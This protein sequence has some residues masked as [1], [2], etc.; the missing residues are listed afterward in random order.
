[1]LSMASK[2]RLERMLCRL[3]TLQTADV[4]IAGDFCSGE[5]LHS[6]PLHDLFC[7]L[8]KSRSGITSRWVFSADPVLMFFIFSGQYYHEFKETTEKQP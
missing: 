6:S 8:V 4:E 1:M 7:D 3:N 5:K 2:S